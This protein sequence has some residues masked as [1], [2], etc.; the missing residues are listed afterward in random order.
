MSEPRYLT[1]REAA[2]VC[3]RHID[4]IRRAERDGLASRKR[5]DGTIE[6]AV[7]DL[8]EFGLLDPLVDTTDIAGAVAQSRVERERDEALQA[9]AVELTR[10]ELL[11]ARVADLR[12][13]TAFL[14]GLVRKQPV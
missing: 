7:A 9:L 13:E 14:R 4:T 10:N 8:V 11:E 5:P 3:G 1:R 6:I 12:D 2:A